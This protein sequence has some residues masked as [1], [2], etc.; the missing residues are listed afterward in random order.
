MIDQI[1][2]EECCGC[3]A[4]AAICPKGCIQIEQDLEGF[5]HPKLNSQNCIECKKC[6]TICPV[7]QKETSIYPETEERVTQAYAAYNTDLLQ[8]Y[9]SS[10]GGI[11]TLLANWVIEKGGIVFGAAFDENFQVKH[12]KVDS[13]E[14]IKKLQGSKYVQSQIGDTFLKTKTYLEEGRFVLFSGTPC[15]IEGLLH[16]LK[17]PYENLITIDVFCTGVPSPKIWKDYLEYRKEQACAEKIEHINFRNKSEGWENYRVYFSFDNGIEYSKGSKEDSYMQGFI[18][19]IFLQ[20]ACYQ[21]KFKEIKH[22][23]DLTLGDF[24]GIR[25]EL[26][27][28]YNFYGVSAILVHSQKGEKILKQLDQIKLKEVSVESVLRGNKNAVKSVTAFARREIFFDAYENQKLTLTEA[29]K[30][31]VGQ[32]I[33]QGRLRQYFNLLKQW[34]ENLQNKQFLYEKLLQKEVHK[35]G[36]IG[37]GDIGRRLKQELELDPNNIEICFILDENEIEFEQQLEEVKSKSCDLIIICSFVD[38]Y[39]LR[40]RLLSK[41]YLKEKIVSL[42]DLVIQ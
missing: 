15:Q 29:I 13:K 41:G 26:P 35:V 10:S 39:E 34:V 8:R 40:E 21:C 33:G 23:S 9:T 27:E 36:L 24:W 22:N 4:C 1:K 6:L 18:R 5:Y 32:D 16:F 25:K 20:P 11:F 14:Q 2:R 12:I 38:F 19:G 17:K 42:K 3:S 28:Y 30:K 31:A 37:L 7:N